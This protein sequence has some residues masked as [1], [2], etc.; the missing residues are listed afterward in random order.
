MEGVQAGR[1]R[2]RHGRGAGSSGEQCGGTG[3]W[4][5]VGWGLWSIEKKLIVKSEKNRQRST[6]KVGQVVWPQGAKLDFVKAQVALSRV[7][8]KDFCCR[9]EAGDRKALGRLFQPTGK[10]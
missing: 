7:P 9:K 5:N 6:Y 4:A 10:K 1:A 2:T 8:L 3:P